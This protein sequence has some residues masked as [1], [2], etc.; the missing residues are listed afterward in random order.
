MKTSHQREAEILQML[1]DLFAN[2]RADLDKHRVLLFG[3]RARG[4]A[5]QRSDFDLAVDGDGPLPL[6]SFFEIAEALEDLPTLYSFDWVDLT[7]VNSRFREEALKSA[8]VIYEG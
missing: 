8:K 3:S 6:K 4:S 7:R 2:R 5:K 1:K